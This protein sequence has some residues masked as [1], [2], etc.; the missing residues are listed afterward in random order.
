MRFKLSADAKKYILR[1]DKDTA[2]RIYAHLRDATANP[3]KGDI[4]LMRDKSGRYRMRVGDFR[5][6][7]EIEDNTMNVGTIGPRGDV[8][9]K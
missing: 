3:P 6:I 1:Q 7:Y 9:K 4:I 8:Y 5:F 2:D